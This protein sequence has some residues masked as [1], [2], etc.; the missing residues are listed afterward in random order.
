MGQGQNQGQS[1][2]MQAGSATSGHAPGGGKGGDDSN[3]GPKGNLSDVNDLERV[4]AE[5]GQGGMVFSSGETKGA[6]D[7]T[8]A[9][10]SVP[11]TDVLSD[12]SKAAESALDKEK[13][14]PAYRVA[15][16]ANPTIRKP[17]SYHSSACSG[18]KIGSA[19]SISGTN[20]IRRSSF[21]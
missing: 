6:P 3:S 20:P 7:E 15:S 13:V 8:G 5:V 21:G 18:S 14:P 11:Y 16:Q 9:N 4:S 10:A 17:R 19:P 12:Y 1:A 2:S